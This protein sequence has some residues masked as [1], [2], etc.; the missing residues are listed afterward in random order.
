M[1][2]IKYDGTLAA[3][4]GPE[5]NFISNNDAAETVSGSAG[6]DSLW[7]GAGDVLKGGAGNDIYWLQALRHQLGVVE[8]P[9]EGVDTIAGW[10]S[11]SLE[12][13]PNIENVRVENNGTYGAGNGLDNIIQGGAGSQ[14]LYGGGGQDI[15]I[16]GAGADVFIVYK[17]E[18]N[19]VVQD[20][21]AAED[22]VRLK[23]GFTSFD[24][25]KGKL[26]QVGG[27]VKLDMGDGHGLMFRNITV[28][29]FTASNFQLQLDVSSLGART[30]TDEFSGP[31]SIWDPQSNPTGTWRPDFGYQGEQGTGSYTLMSNNEKQIYTSPYFRGHNGDFSESPF[32]TNADGT[33]SIW[34]RPSTNGEIFGYGYTSGMITTKES[35]SQTYGYFEMR[36]DI[37]DAAGAWPAFW[38][39]PTD[40]SWPPEL[41]VMEALTSDDN[42]A[43]TTQ[44]SS[45]GGHSSNGNLSYIPDTSDG[46]HTYGALWTP[47]N[48]IWY[49]DGVEV[50][51]TATPADMNKPMFMI[52]N[53]A[54]G[55]WGGE[56]TNGQLPAEFKIDYIRAYDLPGATVAPPPVTPPPVTP[57]PVEPPVVTP[58]PVVVP[59]PVVTP[60]PPPVVS[61]PPAPSTGGGGSS[62]GGGG[63]SV[64]ADP[65]VVLR[66]GN[67]GETLTGLSGN[68]EL[69]G[70]SG[71]D[72]LWGGAGADKIW[73]GDN[74][75]NMHGNEGD[76]RLWGGMGDDW[77][78]GGKD[79]DLLSG[80]EGSDVV[81]GNIGNDF[82]DGG[83]GD[84]IVRGGQNDDTVWGQ[85]GNDWLSGDRGSD[86]L[87][88]GAGADTFHIFAEA[89]VDR[90]TDFNFA[91]GD[92]VFVLPGSTYS[93]AQVGAD[94]VIDVTGGAQLILE[95]TQLSS[96][97]SGWIFGS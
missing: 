89:G 70:G 97:G 29:K 66:A 96:L 79:N 87:T 2:Y 55:G 27:D 73:G 71:E 93:V 48:L 51:R 77:V 59:P 41:D 14:Q 95:N 10:Q 49:I 38:L 54:L 50:F 83:A 62:G 92:K 80:D 58:P 23:A 90:V 63:S 35:H 42:G 69:Y 39:I 7:G 85:G 45:V 21:N 86:T 78:V 12:H 47:Q 20:F 32:V 33:L 18:G 81:L 57:P 9:G 68:D 88:G 15:L 5:S 22:K 30:F 8:N 25:V 67:G 4:T 1:P 56:I 64:G 46:F 61:P 65:Y 76:D 31:L 74:F 53:L 26:T 60:P 34:A 6:A 52:A 72:K 13:F 40:G 94:T 24:Q 84:D 36:A 75:D 19:D 17:G 16:G 43:W 82:V 91:E 28:D 3:E 37:P 11:L 44:H